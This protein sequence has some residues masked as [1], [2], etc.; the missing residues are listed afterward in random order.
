MPSGAM[1]D[2]RESLALRPQK[3]QQGSRSYFPEC[4]NPRGQR[5]LVRWFVEG[6]DLMVAD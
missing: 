1:H 6:G 4:M 3:Q 5:L 2:W